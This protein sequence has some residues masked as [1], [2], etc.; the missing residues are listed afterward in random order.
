MSPPTKTSG[1]AM[2]TTRKGLPLNC[3]NSSMKAPKSMKHAK[4]ADPME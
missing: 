3:E 1:T 2:S 4:E